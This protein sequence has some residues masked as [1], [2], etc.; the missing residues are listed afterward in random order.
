MSPPNGV[1]RGGPPPPLMA[2]LTINETEEY[3]ENDVAI[4]S[5]QG[6]AEI[7]IRMWTVASFQ[8]GLE[9]LQLRPGD[10]ISD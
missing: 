2:L 9:S 6:L 1:T 4:F 3:D 8:K 10:H 7:V 5:W